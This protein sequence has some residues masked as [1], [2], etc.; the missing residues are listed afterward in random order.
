M[1][2]DTA[3]SHQPF[4][5]RLHRLQ[6]LLHTVVLVELLFVGLCFGLKVLHNQPLQPLNLLMPSYIVHTATR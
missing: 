5:L 3:E 6:S 2:C 1:P 4:G